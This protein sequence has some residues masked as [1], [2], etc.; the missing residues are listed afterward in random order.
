MTQVQANVV[1]EVQQ[2]LNQ[3]SLDTQIAELR[4]LELSDPVVNLWVAE[5]KQITKQNV[6]ET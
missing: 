5:V 4:E 1:E 2:R 6:L 3:A